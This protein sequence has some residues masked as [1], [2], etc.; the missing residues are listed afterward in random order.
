[1]SPSPARL[2]W[3]IVAVL[4]AMALAVLDAGM[5]NVALPTLG[6]AFGIPPGEALLAVSAYQLALLIGLLPCAH[7]AERLGF[8]RFFIGGVGLFGFA[9]LLCAVAPS[10]PLLVAIR[11]AQGLGAA[12][13]MA[14][15]VALLRAALGT[16][17]L[18]DAIGWNALTIAICSA[19]GPTLGALVLSL[20]SWR[21]LFL[22]GLPFSIVALI[23]AR[24][25][26]EVGATGDPVDIFA[27]VLHAATAASLFGA[28]R[29]FADHPLVATLWLAAA[30]LSFT[31]LL[32][33]ERGRERPVLPFDLLTRPRFRASVLASVCCF[34]AQSAGLVGLTFYLQNGLGHGPM[35]TG[36][37]LTCWPIAVGMTSIAA[38]RLGERID[39]GGQCALGATLLAIGLALSASLP[40]EGG[41]APLA[42]AAL[43][44]GGGFGMFQLANNRNLFLIAPEERS[45]AAGGMQGTARLMGQ[46]AGTLLAALLFASIASN[47][48]APRAGLAAAAIFAFAAALISWRQSSVSTSHGKAD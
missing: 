44:C 6:R 16:D 42:V 28:M 23:A 46:T 13:I 40:P 19:A 27:I 25:L 26:P 17:R 3:S 7:L 24:R 32:R 31:L 34:T 22:A 30:L 14:L 10:L 4:A 12:A 29:K 41:V 11:S 20:G 21:W 36:L 5:V 47:V 45:A 18:A 9:S 15:G 43:A 33:R 38:R 1:M 2:R 8:R 37:L 35:V 39:A 48:V